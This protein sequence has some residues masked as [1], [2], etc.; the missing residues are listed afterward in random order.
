[1]PN[2]NWKTVEQ[3]APHVAQEII[4]SGVF[5]G[6]G[7]GGM[8]RQ[9]NPQSPNATDMEKPRGGK[10]RTPRTPGINGDDVNMS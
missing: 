1:M 5:K 10:S 2:P 4:A 9:E 6:K 7:E 8:E 3:N